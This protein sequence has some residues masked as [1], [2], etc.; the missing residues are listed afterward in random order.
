MRRKRF[1]RRRD[2]ALPRVFRCYLHRAN[3]VQSPLTSDGGPVPN[4]RQP[5]GDLHLTRSTPLN[6]F[7]AQG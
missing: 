5:G 7:T 3:R 1:R 2:G 4:V 6:R